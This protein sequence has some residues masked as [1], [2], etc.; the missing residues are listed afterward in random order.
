[1]ALSDSLPQI[2]L[3]VQGGTQGSFPQSVYIKKETTSFS[4]F[5]QDRH[6]EKMAPL[7]VPSPDEIAN[8]MPEISKNESNMVSCHAPQVRRA[9]QFEKRWHKLIFSHRV[10]LELDGEMI[11]TIWNIVDV[12][13]NRKKMV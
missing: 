11:A 1:M 3:G 6:P 12:V 4:K 10:H 5:V 2:N 7:K 9:P 8:L 13:Q